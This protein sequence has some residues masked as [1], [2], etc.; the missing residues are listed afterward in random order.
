M[1]L[2]MN[3]GVLN[4]PGE[5]METSS[6]ASPTVSRPAGLTYP[7]LEDLLR[8]RGTPKAPAME[9]MELPWLSSD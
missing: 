4:D 9:L 8:P 2:R 6:W 3:G 7:R 1:L 5:L